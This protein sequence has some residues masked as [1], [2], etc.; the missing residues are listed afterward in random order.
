MVYIDLD[1]A[2]KRAFRG[3]GDEFLRFGFESLY[4]IRE[5]HKILQHELLRICV[6]CGHPGLYRHSGYLLGNLYYP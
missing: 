3:L 4:E 2:G 1:V 6:S 5:F